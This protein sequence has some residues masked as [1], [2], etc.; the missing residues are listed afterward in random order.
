MAK[1]SF[2]NVTNTTGWYV[3]I[4]DEDYHLGI[5]AKDGSNIHFRPA[6]SSITQDQLKEIVDKL[7][8]LQELE[9]KFFHIGDQVYFVDSSWSVHFTKPME[10]K[11]W[12]RNLTM[13]KEP[14]I[15]TKV[16]EC[17]PIASHGGYPALTSCW[18]RNDTVVTRGEET[19]WCNS[20]GIRHWRT[21]K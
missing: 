13:D 11:G 1:L 3:Q 19:V 20:L 18:S 6:G 2:K 5:F 16:N 14:W 4:V 17:L 7:K 9:D 8:E 21:K 12:V 15:V 10:T